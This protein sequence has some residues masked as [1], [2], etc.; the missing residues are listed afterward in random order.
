MGVLLL[1]I[2]VVAACFV[3]SLSAGRASPVM[4]RARASAL[5]VLVFV[6]VN[7]V[8]SDSFAA[9]PGF[10]MVVVLACIIAV[11]RLR[12]P[13][14]ARQPVGAPGPI[15]AGPASRVPEGSG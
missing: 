15:A 5:G 3:G 7:G 12:S 6:L 1:W 9:A 14:P 11:P 4:L 13:V 2:P 8:S 10:E